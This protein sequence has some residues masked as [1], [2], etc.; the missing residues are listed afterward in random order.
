VLREGGGIWVLAVDE[1]TEDSSRREGHK[2]ER[3][4]NGSRSKA[5]GKAFERLPPEETV[6]PEAPT[7]ES[8]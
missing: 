4:A 6:S 7:F 8:R 2:L 3:V 5:S 1:E